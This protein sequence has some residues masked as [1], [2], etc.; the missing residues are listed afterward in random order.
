VAS[1]ETEVW[2]RHCDEIKKDSPF[3]GWQRKRI[4]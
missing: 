2:L 1:P 3:C 4:T